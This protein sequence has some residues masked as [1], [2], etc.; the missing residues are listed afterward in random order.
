MLKDLAWS[1]LHAPN[2]LLSLSSTRSA[3]LFF[4]REGRDDEEKMKRRGGG[5]NLFQ[6]QQFVCPSFARRI[7]RERGKR[8]RERDRKFQYFSS[9][10]ELPASSRPKSGGRER[11]RKGK[12]AVHIST[13]K[14]QAHRLLFRAPR[15]VFRAKQTSE[16]LSSTFFLSLQ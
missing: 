5:R 11:G 12:R 7:K 16:L 2:N 1:C 15:L 4:G 13:N 6:A 8:R 14:R 10:A 9:I 3:C